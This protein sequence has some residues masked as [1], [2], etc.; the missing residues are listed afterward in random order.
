MFRTTRVI[1]PWI[2]FAASLPAQTSALSG[3]SLGFVYDSDAKAIRPILGIPGAAS[4]GQPLD[5]GITVVKAAISAQEDYLLAFSSDAALLL[6]RSDNGAISTD[7]NMSI[8]GVPD[9]IAISPAGQSAVLYY[10]QK[11]VVQVLTGLPK[12]LNG[13]Q[14]VDISGLPNSLDTLAIT[15]DGQYVFAGIPNT[16]T[17][18]AQSGE[19]FIIPVDGTAPRSLFQLGHASALSLLNNSGDM[20]VTDDAKNALYKIT[21]VTGAASVSQVFGPDAQIA[22]PLAVL[23]SPDNQ[24]YFVAAQ[25]GKVVVLDV[26]GGDPV[27]LRCFCTPTVLH[28]LNGRASFQLTE[29]A[30]GLIWMLD[31]DPLEPRFLFVP[32]ATTGNT[33]SSDTD[34][35]T[36]RLP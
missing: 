9:L 22:G 21:T 34:V 31:W 11:A 29:T 14:T 30:D 3:P 2:A 32:P 4:L 28:R 36:P 5:L 24:K 26:A 17:P 1:I 35:P 20:L 25:S 23:P 10:R 13:P 15:D 18:D 27:T 8:A 6:V 33:A 19:V 16:T 12:A 7:T